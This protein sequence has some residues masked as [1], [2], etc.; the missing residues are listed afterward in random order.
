MIFS[1]L[2]E[3]D[4]RTPDVTNPTALSDQ[5]FGTVSTVLMQYK[6]DELHLTNQRCVQAYC[7]KDKELK[8][9]CLVN[10]DLKKELDSIKG[11]QIE[12]YRKIQ[13]LCYRYLNYKTKKDNELF[14]IRMDLENAI[15]VLDEINECHRK[16]RDR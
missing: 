8:E 9:L 1:E 15:Q 10:V 7:R 2:L 14:N 4:T 16:E 11:K 3:G 13:E 5:S 6:Y 12:L